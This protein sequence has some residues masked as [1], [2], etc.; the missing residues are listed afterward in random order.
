MEKRSEKNKQDKGKNIRRRI[1][2]VPKKAYQSKLVRYIFSG[3]TATGIDITSYYFT[4]NF[5]LYKNDFQVGTALIS[6]HI[7]AL[8]V[9]YTLGLIANFLITKYFVFKESNLRGRDQFARYLIIAVI[10]FVANYFMMKI[11]VEVVQIWPTVARIIAAGTI[12][13]LSYKLHK[14]F[15]FRVKLPKL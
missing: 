10:V 3:G 14:V 13:L 2:T 7:A 5:L 8:C 11:L 4:Y 1:R 6:A 15:T 9:S 12:A